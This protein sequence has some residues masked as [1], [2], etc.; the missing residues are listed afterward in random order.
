MRRSST[1][2]VERAQPSER[3][4]RAERGKPKGGLKIP[5]PD[6]ASEQ[7]LIAA[8]LVDLKVRKKLATTLT[9][10]FFFATGHA[11]AWELVL[12][13]ERRS[14]AFD[15]ATAQQLG[16]EGIDVPY[17]CDLIVQRPEVAPNLNH[18]LDTIRWDFARVNAIRGPA[19]ALVEALADVHAEPQRVVSLARSLVTSLEGHD[20]MRYLRDPTGLIREQMAEIRARRAGDACFPFGLEGFD[21]YSD[22]DKAGQWRLIPGAAPGGMTLIT[23]VSG[24]GKTTLTARLAVEQANQQ[25]RVLYGAWEQGSGL[26]L[27]LCASISLNIS[28]AALST[29]QIDD[30]TEKAL[31]LEMERLSEWIRFFELPFDRGRAETGRGRALND[32]HL[33]TMFEY[34][35]TVAPDV[36]VFDL[37]RRAMVDIEPDA[38][39]QALQRQQAMFQATRCH[40]FLVHQLRLKDLEQREDKTPT[41]ESIK[42][43]AAWVEMPDN[44]FAVHREF[45]FK[46]VP[47]DTLRVLILKQ[48]K[49]I[50]PLAVD[51]PWNADTGWIGTGV[52]AECPRPGS[53]AAGLDGFLDGD[54]TSASL[55]A[56]KGGQRRKRL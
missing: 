50:A 26:T 19:G 34:L 43:S 8:A 44:I 31:E 30:D 51:F 16:K 41:R 24:G 42:G 40:G 27:E 9:P 37:W 55:A 11:E 5:M 21:T 33:D 28:R 32:K 6:M 56:R 23:G 47:D 52:S 10:D 35:T 20:S 12:E 7:V 48:R 46:A 3:P 45:L 14:L 4:E 53:K 18:H 36:A 15:P 13:L 1:R 39:E 2:T 29:G 17:L 54:V 25:R 38:E 49:G 22:T